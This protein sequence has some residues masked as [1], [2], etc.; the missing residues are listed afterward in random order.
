VVE[1]IV[2][3]RAVGQLGDQVRGAGAR[4]INSCFNPRHGNVLDG[5]LDGEQIGE[6]LC[7]PVRAAKVQ[8]AE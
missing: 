7:C 4:A 8:R 2:P 3:A 1:K 6:R 5:A